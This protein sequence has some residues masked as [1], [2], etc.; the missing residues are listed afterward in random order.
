MSSMTN[1]RAEGEHCAGL[2]AQRAE[3]SIPGFTHRVCAAIVAYLQEHGP[4]SG[5]HITDAVK[6]SGLIP[7]DDRAFGSAYACL[8]R[9]GLIVCVGYAPRYK[10]RGTGGARIWKAVA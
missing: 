10:G 2:A 5:E 7:A 8:A 1:A 4:T 3:R 6:R 9:D